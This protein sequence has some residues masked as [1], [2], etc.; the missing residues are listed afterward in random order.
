[1][2]TL[3]KHLRSFPTAVPYTAATQH[4]FLASAGQLAI[5]PDLLSFYLSQDRS[6]AA[7]AYPRFIGTLISRIPFDSTS[8]EQ[9][10]LNQRILSLLVFSLTNVVREVNFFDDTAKECGLDLE[11]WKERKGTKDYV[12]EMA[13]VASLGTL[14]D[15]LIFLWAM[16]QVSETFFLRNSF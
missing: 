5:K 16:E 9:A 12:A 15:G 13:R 6:Y 1:M 4:P 10:K 7:H 14:E 3:A 11:G 2:D 8:P